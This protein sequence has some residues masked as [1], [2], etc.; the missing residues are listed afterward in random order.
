[1]KY[2]V[3]VYYRHH[4]NIFTQTNPTKHCTHPSKLNRIDIMED[5]HHDFNE[6]ELI[7]DYIQDNRD[8]YAYPEYDE[9]EYYDEADESKEKLQLPHPP[10]N[11]AD[12][13]SKNEDGDINTDIDGS[14][15]NKEQTIPPSVIIST[16]PSSSS[17][18]NPYSFER[19]SGLSAWRSS[20]T[21]NS[22][23]NKYGATTM[24][25]TAWKKKKKRFSNDDDD[26]DDES[27]YDDSDHRP[28]KRSNVDTTGNKLG[29]EAQL[30]KMHQL[31]YEESMGRSWGRT[32]STSEELMQDYEQRFVYKETTLV[33]EEQNSVMITVGNGTTVNIPL[34]NNN[35]NNSLR[36]EHTNGGG[37]GMATTD[38]LVR[39]A[40][41]LRKRGIKRQLEKEEQMKK[42]EKTKRGKTNTTVVQEEDVELNEK[43]ETDPPLQQD[44]TNTKDETQQ[45]QQQQIIATSIKKHRREMQHRQRL[46]VDK[47]AP[48]SI[49][50]LLSD[51]RTNR[52][53]IRALKLWDPYVFRRDAPKRPVGWNNNGGFGS[54]GNSK[55]ERGE[56]V[57]QKRK[58]G[59]GDTTN[60]EENDN[61]EKNGNNNGKEQ[62]ADVRPEESS[63]VIL[64]SGPPGVGKTTLAHIVCR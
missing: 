33:P 38:E 64:L 11:N 32:G 15:D 21:N 13:P 35:S 51:E 9:E 54:G 58:K 28:I 63:R 37:D 14:I 50:H 26:N 29:P 20:N 6:D 2:C 41:I 62:K 34:K 4:Y 55:Y 23:T 46:W 45:R 22:N 36:G 48:T 12:A 17:S 59:G 53:V 52:E 27:D 47:H 49:S 43:E 40:D 56:K 61:G 30:V 24:E 1:M 3:S 44:D 10:S 42:K 57:K 39:R 31:S 19:Y 16:K 18:S 25:A 5:Y 8:D 7:N 60:E